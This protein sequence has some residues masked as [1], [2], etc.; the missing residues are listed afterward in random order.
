MIL[1]VPQSIVVIHKTPV[2]QFTVEKEVNNNVHFLD[3]HVT[4]REDN[5]IILD[6]YITPTIYGTCL[7]TVRY[8]M[9]KCTIIG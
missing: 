7:Q 4:R 9:Q 5:T 3:K 8:R 1:A 6:W 2:L